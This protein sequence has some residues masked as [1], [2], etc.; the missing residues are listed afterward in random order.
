MSESDRERAKQIAM[1]ASILLALTLAVCGALVGRHYLPGLLGDWAGVMVGLI[2]T[3]FILEASFIIIGLCVVMW[4]NHCR[5]RREGDEFVYLDQLDDESAKG[6]PDQAKWATYRNKPLKGE[7]PGLLEQ[8]EGAVA[9][10]DYESATECIAAM[11]E[12]ELKRPA[13]LELRLELAKATGKESLVKQLEEELR[14]A[15]NGVS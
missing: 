12:V 1:G 7:M 9:I 8:A 6:L 5:E 13:T 14:A 2:T 11:S 3:P 4:I 10:G 15:R